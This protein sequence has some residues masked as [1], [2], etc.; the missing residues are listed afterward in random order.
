MIELAL[1]HVNGLIHERLLDLAKFVITQLKGLGRDSCL[2]PV[3][4]G[5]QNVW[6]EIT[7]QQQSDDHSFNWEEYVNLVES[8]AAL[9]LAKLSRFEIQIL[10]FETDAYFDWNENSSSEPPVS[11][12]D[13]SSLVRD[14]VLRLAGGYEGSL[15]VYGPP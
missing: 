10:W 15:A 2:S 9:V 14:I 8:T 12:E 4:S 5:L 11:I 7:F 1:P 13:V 3:D 6:E